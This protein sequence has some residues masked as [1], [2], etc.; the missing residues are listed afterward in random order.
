MKK[1]IAKLSR[2]WEGKYLIV[3][4]G[5]QEFW[6]RGTIGD[7]ISSIPALLEEVPL[8]EK[9]A[10]EW[11]KL[12]DHKNDSPDALDE[13]EASGEL[14]PL[15]DDAEFKRRSFIMKKRIELSLR[16]EQGNCPG[17]GLDETVIV[18]DGETVE[19]VVRDYTDYLI[20]NEGFTA[21]EDGIEKD[22]EKYTVE[23]YEMED[24]VNE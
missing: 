10:A 20:A 9:C 16:D 1:T 14:L 21:C 8:E 19:S 12:Y 3:I 22:G 17:L 15:M 23:A 11:R 2:D 5:D 24:E 13:L 18:K 4:N 7:A 6:G